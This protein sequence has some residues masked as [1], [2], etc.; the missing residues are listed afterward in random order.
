V[1][2]I[3]DGYMFRRLSYEEDNSL[4]KLRRFAWLCF[5][6][7]LLVAVI[8]CSGLTGMRLSQPVTGLLTV[9]FIDVGQGDSILIET[10]SGKTMLVDGGE[11]TAGD[12]VIGVLREKGIGRINVMV[13][14]HPHADHIGGL[15]KVLEEL[16]VDSVYDSAKP[17]SSKTY[18][19]Y[20]TLIFDKDIPF[21]TA[22]A[23]DEILLDDSVRI[24][25]VWPPNTDAGNPFHIEKLSVNDASVVLRV[26]F[27][28]S[29]LLLTGDAEDVVEN[30]LIRRGSALQAQVLKIA[31]HGSITSSTDDFLN[32]VKPEIA[33]ICVG[34][35][36]RYGHPHKEVIKSLIYAGAKILRTDIHGTIVLESD[37]MTWTV[38]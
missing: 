7:T 8:G 10:P 38:K 15:I 4:T 1:D 3:S 9:T 28:D 27:G 24:A 30:E 12:E 25:I 6:V 17:H 32:E 11:R 22:R 18:E 20:L 21:Y 5:V 2:S 33:V 16:P 37:G 14:T 19:D 29:V 31:H 36:N 23:G 13:S 34:D 35:G 26:E